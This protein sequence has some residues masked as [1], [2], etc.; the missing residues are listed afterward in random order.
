M[1]GPA[2]W[3]TTSKRM[4]GFVGVSLRRAARNWR[5]VRPRAVCSSDKRGTMPEQSIPTHPSRRFHSVHPGTPVDTVDSP[6]RE[7]APHMEKATHSRAALR[8]SF[9]TGPTYRR[10]RRKT[11]RL[12]RPQVSRRFPPCLARE[13][14]WMQHHSRLSCGPCLGACARLSR[15]GYTCRRHRPRRTRAC[16]VTPIETHHLRAAPAV[17]P[18]SAGWNKHILGPTSRPGPLHPRH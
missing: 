8:C 5:L 4:Q 15:H 10:R 1:R 6:G 9:I 7:R 3:P 11:T 18:T 16:R 13:E 14:G 12:H 17:A 2:D